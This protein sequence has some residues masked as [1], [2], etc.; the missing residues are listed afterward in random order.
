MGFLIPINFFLGRR[1]A[2]LQKRILIYRDKRMRFLNE[3]IGKI[4]Y[5]AYMILKFLFRS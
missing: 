2:V 3:V 1:N 5:L 4:P